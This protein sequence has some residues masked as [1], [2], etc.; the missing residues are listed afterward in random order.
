[1]KQE[2]TLVVE[3]GSFF[4]ELPYKWRLQMVGHGPY[5]TTRSQY[6]THK[7]AVAA[8]TR[9]AVKWGITITATEG[10]E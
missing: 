4:N 6:R 2:A 1:M 8:A 10:P 7:N 9:C 5:L 3:R